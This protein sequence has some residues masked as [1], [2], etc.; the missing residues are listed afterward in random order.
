LDKSDAIPEMSEEYNGEGEESL[1]RLARTVKNPKSIK[2]KGSNI[3]A[4]ESV[5]YLSYKN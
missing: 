3:E 5:T 1:Q 2:A 4:K